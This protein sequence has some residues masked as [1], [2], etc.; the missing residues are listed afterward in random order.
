M[1][2][3]SSAYSHRQRAS[4]IKPYSMFIVFLH[5]TF[6]C[7]SL[8]PARVHHRSVHNLS[9]LR[10]NYIHKH[11]FCGSECE[12]KPYCELL[13]FPRK[14]RCEDEETQIYCTCKLVFEHI[15]DVGWFLVVV[16][17]QRSVVFDSSLG[18]LAFIWSA[19]MTKRLTVLHSLL[20]SSF[21]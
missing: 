18:M 20:L 14:R 17:I 19:C 13:T 15:P 6:T 16:F 4:Q 21:F 1:T 11:F 8:L 9:H 3:Y 12:R 5:K 10:G 2:S 7:L